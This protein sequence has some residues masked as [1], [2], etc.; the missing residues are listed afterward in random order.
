MPA[1]LAALVVNFNTAELTLRSVGSILA[2]GVAR[3]LVL[4]NGSEAADRRLLA[5]GLQRWPGAVEWVQEECNLGFAQGCNILFERVL[6][7]PGIG[8]VLLLNSDAVLL[9]GGLDRLLAAAATG[10]AMVGGRVDRHPDGVGGRAPELESLG[11][12]LYRSLLASNRKSTADALLGP[13]GACA[14]YTREL[15]LDLKA[16]HGYIFDPDYFCYAEDTD[17]CIRARLLGYGAVCVDE[18]VALHQGQASSGGGYNDF[19]M[20]HGV[21][22][23]IWTMVKT[24]PPATLARNAFWIVLLHGGIVLR[25]LRRGKF[26]VLLGLYYS[27]FK[28]MPGALRKRAAIQKARRI[29]TAEFDALVARGLYE[30]DYVRNALS[31]VISIRGGKQE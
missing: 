17:L 9:E 23:S 10:A 31:E 16:S 7:E 28:G 11:I 18:C 24:T 3:V 12:T 14:L 5:E 1:Q 25:H 29:S 30:R 27:A 8:H 19:I 22:N 26:R 20:F 2:A 4:D 15:L 21:R 13:T 6:G